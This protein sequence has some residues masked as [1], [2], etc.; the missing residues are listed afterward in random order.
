[1]R[2]TGLS[3]L[4]I[5]I[6]LVSVVQSYDFPAEKEY[7]YFSSVSD[8]DLTK[9][10]QI[11][12]KDENKYT[13]YIGRDFPLPR[14]VPLEMWQKLT[15][16]NKSFV[17]SIGL[18]VPRYN[19]G[20]KFTEF[21]YDQFNLSQLTDEESNS[22]DH[23]RVIEHNFLDTDG[24]CNINLYA[25]TT[26]VVGGSQYYISDAQNR[27]KNMLDIP[28]AYDLGYLY[29]PE[30]QAMIKQNCPS[31]FEDYYTGSDYRYWDSNMGGFRKHP[32]INDIC[33]NDL[34]IS[35]YETFIDYPILKE[36]Y[37]VNSLFELS[38]A[39][40]NDPL[41]TINVDGT[42]TLGATTITFPCFG[43]GTTLNDIYSPI[44]DFIINLLYGTGFEPYT[45]KDRISDLISAD[46][47]YSTCKQLIND[48]ANSV[49]TNPFVTFFTL[50]DPEIK[51]CVNYI[52]DKNSEACTQDTYSAQEVQGLIW[53]S[54]RNSFEIPQGTNLFPFNIKK[55]G[56]KCD[57]NDTFMWVNRPFEPTKFGKDKLDP[58]GEL[59]TAY[60]D[61]SDSPGL[62]NITISVEFVGNPVFALV[63]G[64]YK[65][66]KAYNF[67]ELK[68]MFQRVGILGNGTITTIQDTVRWEFTH[69]LDTQKAEGC[70]VYFTEEQAGEAV[71]KFKTI[72]DDTNEEVQKTADEISK[73]VEVE[74]RLQKTEPIK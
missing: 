52:D 72:I 45:C 29:V 19:D 8:S 20:V 54:Y 43:K 28:I 25:S 32:F 4:F 37:G 11:N 41:N 47:T 50:I 57:S 17:T 64:E 2:K 71:T 56:V 3:F 66:N 70:Y 1:M 33:L 62:H 59:S 60:C 6:L 14:Y 30:I 73:M 46:T 10:S 23:V 39:I 49:F 24:V 38:L 18:H 55:L 65:V 44:D 16:A 26:D 31:I 67:E 58:F 21:R 5:L 42:C 9:M 34:D 63:A 61:Y 40:Y 7:D 51:N 22:I 68:N 15:N 27:T 69:S 13:H 74:L 48:R 36:S 12:L 35:D 53:D